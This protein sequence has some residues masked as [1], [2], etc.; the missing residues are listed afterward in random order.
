MY[1]SQHTAKS[2]FS[3]SQGF[4]TKKTLSQLTPSDSKSEK[5]SSSKGKIRVKG[6]EN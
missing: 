5:D 2:V 4:L 6:K 3:E 1:N